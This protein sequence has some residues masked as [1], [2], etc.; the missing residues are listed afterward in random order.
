MEQMFSRD[1]AVQ[2]RHEILRCDSVTGFVEEDIDIFRFRLVAMEERQ[3]D[4]DFRNGIEGAAT[5]LAWE[6]Q[7]SLTRYDQRVLERRRLQ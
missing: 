3:Q 1:M 5:K 7:I 6:K 4:H 2:D